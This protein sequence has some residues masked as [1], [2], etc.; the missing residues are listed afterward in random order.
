MSG[1][2]KKLELNDVRSGY[3]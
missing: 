3:F 2:I 1:Y